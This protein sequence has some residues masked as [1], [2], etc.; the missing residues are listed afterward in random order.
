MRGSA[1]NGSQE[2]IEFKGT[3][4]SVV[5]AVLHSVDP[6]VLADAL[7][8]RLRRTPNFF[9][10]EALVLDFSSIQ[11]QP[12]QVDW[13]HIVAL[14]K[15]AQLTPVAVRIEGPAGAGAAAVGL[16][17][18]DDPP[19]RPPATSSGPSVAPAPSNNAAPPPPAARTLIVDRPLRSGQQ[20]YAQGGDLIVLGMVSP[21]AEVIADGSVH[22]YAPLRGRAMAGVKGNKEAR[23]FCTCFEPEIVSIAGLFKVFDSGVPK[24]LARQPTQVRFSFQDGQAKL[25]T[26]LLKLN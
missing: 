10:G 9:S 20:V 14:F 16:A 12:E 15:R 11:P 26:E 18:V 22:I 13:P 4:L 8:Q 25:I 3:T 19:H 17:V 2:P 1:T 6:A 24:E 5:N 21:G 7:E 23:I